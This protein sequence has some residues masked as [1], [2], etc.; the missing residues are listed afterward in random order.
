M[1]TEKKYCYLHIDIDENGKL[2]IVDDRGH[3]VYGVRS[4]TV[5]VIGDD[6]TT[7]NMDFLPSI[8][9]DSSPVAALCRHKVK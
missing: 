6:K 7:A 1:T 8:K 2:I 5:N 3:K 4:A 9:N